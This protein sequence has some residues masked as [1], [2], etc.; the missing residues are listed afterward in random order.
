MKLNS[1]PAFFALG[2]L[3]A[4]SADASPHRVV[5]INQKVVAPGVFF[6]VEGNVGTLRGVVD[7]NLDKALLGKS[8]IALEGIDEVRNY[9]RTRN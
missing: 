4:G 6:C 1:L 9:L 7:T 5:D 3:I 2:L 8:A